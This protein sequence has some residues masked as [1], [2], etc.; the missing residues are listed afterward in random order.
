MVIDEF[1]LKGRIA[2]V[3]GANKGLGLS[4][5]LALAEAGADIVALTRTTAPELEEGVR[6]LG[7]RYER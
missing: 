7:R 5:A 2:A 1:S 6:S 3:T 4:M